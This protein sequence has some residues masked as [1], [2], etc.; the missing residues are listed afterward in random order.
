[1]FCKY[2]GKEQKE[3]VVFCSMCGKQLKHVEAKKEV[4]IKK[5]CE[6]CGQEV[7]EENKFCLNC[8][9][10]LDTNT[11]EIKKS[12]NSSFVKKENTDVPKYVPTESDKSRGLAAILAFVFGEFGAHRFYVG[13]KVSAI[14]QI[15][16]GFSF[17]IGLICLEEYEE[18]GFFFIFLGIGWCIWIL[19]DFIT[20]LCGA[21]KDKDNLPLTDWSF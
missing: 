17:I 1:M 4:I 11:E 14:W 9:H 2:C 6:Q 13:K 3:D 16:L 5:F 21:F 19:I 12:S 8:G 18:I 10:A 7:S 15:V 20:I